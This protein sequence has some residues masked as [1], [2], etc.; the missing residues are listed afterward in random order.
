VIDLFRASPQAGAYQGLK[1]KLLKAFSRTPMERANAVMDWQ[2]LGDLKPLALY[3]K[4]AATLPD[5]TDCNH[6]L[7]KACFIRQLPPDVRDHLSDK[8]EQS[9]RA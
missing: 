7:V 5:G 2:G 6:I 4:M 9:T 8:M 3:N 1:A